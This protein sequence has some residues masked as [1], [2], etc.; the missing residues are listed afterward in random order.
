MTT[1]IK[2]LH[3]ARTAGIAVAALM[4]ATACSS[5]GGGSSSSAS[6]PAGG[7]AASSSAA[8]PASSAA[9]PGGAASSSGGGGSSSAAAASKVELE[10][11]KS[12]FGQI[13][14]DSTGRTVYMFA[15]DS[16]TKSTCYGQCAS[17]WPPV[18]AK[19]AVEAS[20]GIDKSKIKTLK[21]TDGT[22]QVVYNGWPLYYFLQDQA[23]GD[24]NGQGNTNFGAAWWVL[25]PAGEPIKKS[26]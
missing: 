6:A 18:L 23:P 21:R 16:P 19:G 4:L 10:T 5:S 1:Q 25:T 12:K 11:Q 3:I 7:G 20:D 17:F 2:N 13:V 22:T 24:T 9:A 14:T 8:A 26:A 15:S